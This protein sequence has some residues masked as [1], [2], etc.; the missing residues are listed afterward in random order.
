MAHEIIQLRFHAYKT[1]L[2]VIPFLLIAGGMDITRTWTDLLLKPTSFRWEQMIRILQVCLFSFF[3]DFCFVSCSSTPSS[4]K[5]LTIRLVMRQ[6]LCFV[7]M[8]RRILLGGGV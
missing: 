3:K 6:S 8:T 1:F 2:S 7:V 5:L 4:S